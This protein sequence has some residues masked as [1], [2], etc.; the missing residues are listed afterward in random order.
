MCIKI[1][2]RNKNIPRGP[3]DASVHCLG[4]FGH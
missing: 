2:T 3:S 4:P 1:E